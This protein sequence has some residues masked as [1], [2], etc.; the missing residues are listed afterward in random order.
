M[1]EERQKVELVCAAR[2]PD[3]DGYRTACRNLGRRKPDLAKDSA[4][5]DVCGSSL[6]PRASLYGEAC[7]VSGD[8]LGRPEE[9]FDLLAGRSV[10]NT[11]YYAHLA[12]ENYAHF[13]PAAPR[14]W[15]QY[16]ATAEK[17]AL[18]AHGERGIKAI[19]LLE[20]AIY[21]N[22]FADHFLQDAFAAGHMGFNRA[23]TGVAAAKAMHDHWNESGRAM[24]N[25]LGEEWWGYG[26]G[27]LCKDTCEILRR[28]STESIFVI[29]R[30]GMT[31]KVD[32]AEDTH[33]WMSFASR[34]YADTLRGPFGVDGSALSGDSP[35]TG[36]SWV[37][38]GSF[39][40]PA[41]VSQAVGIEGAVTIVR[42]TEITSAFSDYELDL[43]RPVKLLPIPIHFDFGIG[44]MGDYS[45]ARWSPAAIAKYIVS[46]GFTNDG[47][48][49]HDVFYQA[50]SMLAAVESGHRFAV[51][52]IGYRLS[53]EF[54]QHRISLEPVGGYYW[55]DREHF[56]TVSVGLA[57]SYVVSAWGGGALASG[58]L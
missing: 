40:F 4:F 58:T 31:G 52:G 9:F 23:A 30:T 13:F 46:L 57:Y 50:A 53:A 15:S 55:Y 10:Y 21:E 45:I 35:A 18:S 29:I 36:V 48:L 42:G 25:G 12:L 6:D 38:S 33:I 26:D 39:A 43:G 56:W 54:G 5:E 44:A 7:A 19:E 32:T 11:V 14:Y 8:H 51:Q 49:A 22:A 3:S 47:F 41:R 17:T 34:I 2:D 24:E 28:A 27:H 20:R 1:R 16:H 37:A